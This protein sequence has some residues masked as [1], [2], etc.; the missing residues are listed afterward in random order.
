MFKESYMKKLL[1]IINPVTAKVTIS[2]HLVD[3]V[4]IFE[5][6]GYD[7]NIHISKRKNDIKEVTEQTGSNYD[8]VVCSG[9]DGTL[10]ETVS[11]VLKLDKKPKIGYI[12]AGTTNDFAQSWGIPRKPLD[13]AKSIVSTDPIKTDV[14]M[15][16]GRPFIY[17]AAFG[18]FTKVSYQTP[19]QM[20][21]NLGYTAYL[22]EGIKSIGTIRPWK[23]EL[24]HDHG[25][26][27]GEFLYGMI[28][29]TRK[30]GGFDLKMKNDIS[31]SDGLMEVILVKKPQNPADNPKML[32]AVLSQDTSSEYITFEHVKQIEFTTDERLP[33][34]VDGEDG[35][36]VK[37]GKVEIIERAI[38]LFY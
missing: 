37:Q 15:F 16:C 2:P 5:K 6:S 18:A 11:G 33:W 9:G 24:K 29:N 20:K 21:R 25:T 32:G 4:D 22:F 3:I 19:Q 26:V 34:T 10:N 35:G 36:I 12:P 13:A 38:E 23:M 30:I 27:E 17:V 14:S 31:I 1:L 8:V 28:S 7:V